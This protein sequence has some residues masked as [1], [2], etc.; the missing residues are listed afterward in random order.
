MRLKEVG[1][2]ARDLL[3]AVVVARIFVTIQTLLSLDSGTLSFPPT[4]D[5]TGY[6]IDAFDRLGQIA[7]GGFW[8]G[9]V[10]MPP[11]APGSTALAMAGFWAFGIHPYSAII[12][13]TIPLA[14]FLFIGLRLQRHTPFLAAAGVVLG[15][16]LLPF[17]GIAVT[18]FRPDLWCAAFIMVGLAA[19]C[20]R[21]AGTDTWVWS[22]VAFGT[23]LLMKPTFAPLTILLFGAAILLRFLPSLLSRRGW[24]G[25]LKAGVIVLGIA[26]VLAGPYFALTW[27]RI[28]DYYALHVF[29][30]GAASWTPDLSVTQ[31]LLYY[32]SGPG[33]LP[34][35]GWGLYPALLLIAA[36]LVAFA[37]GRRETAWKLTSYAILVGI[38][39][40]VVTIPGNKS[41]FLGV[42]F[43]A[44]LVGAIAA[45][46]IWVT[47]RRPYAAIGI[48]LLGAVS[49]MTPWAALHGAPYPPEVARARHNLNWQILTELRKDP[50]LASKKVMFAQIAQYT[51]AETLTVNAAELGIARPV[52][53]SEYFNDKI[54][55]Q[56]AMIAASDYVITISPEYPGGLSWV[57]S[58]KIGQ[59]INAAL[60]ADPALALVQTF[61][62]PG[63]PGEFRIYKRI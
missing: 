10:A 34:F 53:Q 49:Y 55:A 30:S 62:P 20:F 63:E 39:Y 4:Y 23:A 24:A 26:V 14:T 60:D 45:A 42:G 11:H 37:A 17:W 47:S 33:G 8:Q 54:E 41:P 36:P 51:N 2:I 16:L 18:E 3:F 29:G 31:T 48:L 58:A 15:L 19:I 44:L 9:V 38:A 1:F 52:F 35:L 56:R 43:V 12:A 7:S 27:R 6:Y 57:P 5:A 32:I 50:D 22:G 61:A 25:M 46:S 59:Q 28:V 13:S 40:L 21:P